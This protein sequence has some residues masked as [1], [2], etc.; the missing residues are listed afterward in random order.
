MV[1]IPKA[2]CAMSK[3]SNDAFIKK[4]EKIQ[5][6]LALGPYSGVAPPPSSVTPL[7][8][9]MKVYQA[10][11]EEHNY[12]NKLQLE[13]I[14]KDITTL[15]RLQCAS[16]NGLAAGN[17]DF[18]VN[19][20]FDISK[21]PEA[22][23]V[24]EKGVVKAVKDEDGATAIIRTKALRFCKIYELEIDG[25]NGFLR[26]D[27]GTASKFKAS[28]LPQGVTLSAKVRGRNGRGVGEWSVPFPFVVNIKPEVN[29]GTEE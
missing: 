8:D 7:I 19:S 6:K 29:N 25:P 13:F 9:Q 4:A 16:V 27:F 18:L 15:L 1:Y 28:D 2:T 5:G 12:K 10:E 14:R 21:E 23:T 20:G 26:N 17:I 24:P 11:S 22:H 3:Y